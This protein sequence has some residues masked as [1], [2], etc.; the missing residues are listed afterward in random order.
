MKTLMTALALALSCSVA[1]AQDCN[2]AEEPTLPVRDVEHDCRAM[3]EALNRLPVE[4]GRINACVDS[5]QGYYNEDR[6][7]WNCISPEGRKR[8]IAYAEKRAGSEGVYS[9]HT[10]YGYLSGA[11]RGIGEEESRQRPSH[12]KPW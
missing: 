9:A 12:F 1:A 3:L 10:F 4:Q 11:L 5:A 8:A 6:V 2:F 7:L